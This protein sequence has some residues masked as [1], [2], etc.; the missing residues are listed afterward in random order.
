MILQESLR[1][2]HGDDRRDQKALDFLNDEEEHL[3]SLLLQYHQNRRVLEH[4]M[5]GFGANDVPLRIVNEMA[6]VKQRIKET[7]SRIA[8]VCRDRR[9]L[10]FLAPDP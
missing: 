9:A 10:R 4:Q 8:D 5:A 2:L 6:S 7:S 3:R 1:L